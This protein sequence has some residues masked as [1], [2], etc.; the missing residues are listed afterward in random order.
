M[1]TKLDFAF[2]VFRKYG[3]LVWF[4]GDTPGKVGNQISGETF[5]AWSRRVLK[6][7]H[8]D[9]VVLQCKQVAPNTRIANL[10]DE[11][12]RAIATSLFRDH[13]NE[14]SAAAT[15]ETDLLERTHAQKIRK[16]QEKLELKNKELA[17][18]QAK[19]YKKSQLDVEN[20][21]KMFKTGIEREIEL[22]L[23]RTDSPLDELVLQRL[24]KFRDSLSS[25]TDA[26]AVSTMIASL[27]TFASFTRVERKKADT[28]LAKA[29]ELIRE[30]GER[31]ESAKGS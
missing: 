16:L 8:S 23:E 2:K 7:D 3:V 10:F 28:D 13:A 27:F 29:N 6:Q 25:E 4:E 14:A 24:R 5:K 1:S 17:S 15:V 11:E 9:V 31:L 26:S 20:E 18:A 30:L 21:N 19:L 22:L 12:M